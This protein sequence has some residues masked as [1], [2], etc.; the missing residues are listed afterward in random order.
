M[1]LVNFEIH[2]IKITRKAPQDESGSYDQ[3]GNNGN[4]KK[5]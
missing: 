2:S 4:P 5:S 1:K 3:S